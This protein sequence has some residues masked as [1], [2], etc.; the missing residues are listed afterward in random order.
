MTIKKQISELL[1]EQDC[2]IVAGLGGFIANYVP[3]AINPVTHV[4]TPPCRQ[5]AFNAALRNNDG[6]LANHLVR[7]LGIGYAEAV[8]QIEKQSLAWASGLNRG[9]KISF[10][11]IGHLYADKEHHI[12]FVPE[13]GANLLD[14]AFGLSVFS[15]QPVLSQERSK[16]PVQKITRVSAVKSGRKLPASLKWAAILL[17][18]AALSFW[19]AH[20]TGQM[21][22]IYQNSATVIPAPAP[23]AS[24]SIINP[25]IEVKKTVE[26]P[27]TAIEITDKKIEA[28]LPAIPEVKVEPDQYFIIAGAFGVKENADN[29]VESLISKGYNAA[30]EG[31]NSNGLYLVSIESFAVKE[32]AL[33]KTQELRNGEYPSAWL[34]TMR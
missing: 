13:K 30:I 26:A 8:T 32:V 7:T 15:T 12:H 6:I 31:Q 24:Q 10:D 5:V 21:N 25:F 17:P 3:A 34:L 16:P 27:A 14:D 23:T 29:M 20:N 9:E 19:S 1:K 2:V 11:T 4:F 22:A 33:E 28:E 18:L